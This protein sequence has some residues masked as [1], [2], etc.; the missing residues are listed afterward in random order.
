[1]VDL[2]TGTVTFLFTDL[3]GSTRRWEQQPDAMQAAL[4]R[5]DVI[6]RDAMG[7][8][9]GLV[10][11]EMGD[12]IAAAFASASDAVAAAIEAQLGLGAE[13]W[14]EIGDLQA[15]MG[16]HASVVELRAD[17]QYVNQPVGC[18]NSVRHAASSYS[19]MR[20]PSRSRRRTRVRDS[21]EPD[22]DDDRASGLARPRARWGDGCC[23]DRRRDRRA[24]LAATPK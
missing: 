16:L 18:R 14:G 3:E 7:S 13:E 8:H 24:H 6:L 23:S 21:S 4:A 19:W 10:F 11:S 5:H 12:G 22:G 2:P 15:R 17:G 9:R 1:M 20:P